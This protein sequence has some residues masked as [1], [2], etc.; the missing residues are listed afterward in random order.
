MKNQGKLRILSPLKRKKYYINPNLTS[1]EQKISL[2]VEPYADSTK[3]YWFNN[4]I[5]IS[6]GKS[7]EKFFL[8]LEAGK[9][10]IMCLDNMGRYDIVTI[11]IENI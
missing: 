10:E 2:I 11:E 4:G 6:E 8:T 3:L 9:Q 1:Q 7:D 5:I